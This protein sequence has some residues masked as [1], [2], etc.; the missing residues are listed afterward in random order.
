MLRATQ[1]T[2]IEGKC[3]GMWIYTCT[4]HMSVH[5]TVHVGKICMKDAS[6]KV[7]QNTQEVKYERFFIWTRQQ[8]QIIGIIMFLQQSDKRTD[9]YLY[10]TITMKTEP[11][12][13]VRGSCT[14][15]TSSAE[16]EFGNGGCP[17]LRELTTV[18]SHLCFRVF[19][20]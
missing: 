11:N 14:E 16:I 9:R 5:A 8:M 13:T 20:H 12:V 10:N 18:S 6:L 15:T 4:A 1:A 2:E 17:L 3:V 7:N 19:S